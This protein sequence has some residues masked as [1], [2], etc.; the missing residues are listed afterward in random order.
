MCVLVGTASQ[1]NTHKR[2]AAVADKHGKAK[3]NHRQRENDSIRR[4]A[5]RAEVA[6]VCD[7]NLIY[8]IIERT[9]Q[10]RDDTRDGILLHQPPNRLRPQKLI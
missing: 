9:D 8:N 7:K 4:V 2:T 6:G 3:G 10:K 1:R 5:I